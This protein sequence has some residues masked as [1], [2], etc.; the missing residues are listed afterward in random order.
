[1]PGTPPCPPSFPSLEFTH[2]IQRHVADEAV[3]AHRLSVCLRSRSSDAGQPPVKPALGPQPQLHTHSHGPT[4]GAQLPQ[5][6]LLDGGL[7]SRQVHA[8][9]N[10]PCRT[11]LLASLRQDAEAWMGEQ[12]PGAQPWSSGLSRHPGEPLRRAGEHPAQGN[13]PA[14]GTHGYFGQL[15]S[16]R[17][18][19]T[20]WR[21]EGG[22]QAGEGSTKPQPGPG[23]RCPVG[24]GQSGQE[25]ACRLPAGR[26]NFL[27]GP[28][29]PGAVGQREASCPFSPDPS[30]VPPVCI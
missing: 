7:S 5:Q 12:G 27:R 8:P 6:G 18:T 1:M 17:L 30:R 16:G 24:T 11:S 23:Q 25:Q 2:L 13:L 29:L 21:Q 10:P 28:H 3:A 9:R 20:G 4:K 14:T 19:G 22:V 15:H 26:L